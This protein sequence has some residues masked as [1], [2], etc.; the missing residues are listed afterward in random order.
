MIR[1]GIL[2]QIFSADLGKESCK[3][4]KVMMGLSDGVISEKGK[5]ATLEEVYP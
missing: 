5:T 4:D 3:Y 2:E 1:A